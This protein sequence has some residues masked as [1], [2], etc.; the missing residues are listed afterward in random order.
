MTRFRRRSNSYLHA[1][2]ESTRPAALDEDAPPTVASQASAGEAASETASMRSLSMKSVRD[3]SRPLSTQSLLA[4]PGDAA[5]PTALP[6]SHAS[7]A[8]SVGSPT[9]SIVVASPSAPASASTSP[10]RAT[11]DGSE[12]LRYPYHDGNT[13]VK[14]S[15][16]VGTLTSTQ[17]SALAALRQRVV[18]EKLA[19]D[20]HRCVPAESETHLLLRFL[21]AR[22]FSV[23]KAWDMLAADIAW[24][25]EYG[26]LAL[27]DLS[28]AAVVQCDVDIV[29]HHLPI[30]HAGFDMQ[31]RPV[32]YKR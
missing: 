14:D 26:V 15:G 21:R 29:H 10:V 30:W 23:D 9:K 19:I 28:M 22:Q 6:A 4:G 2:L 7:P 13:T 1:V 17:L 3:I 11:F 18:A 25:E 16:Y 27:R 8:S 24:R 31:G 32:V 12:E 20:P 5:T